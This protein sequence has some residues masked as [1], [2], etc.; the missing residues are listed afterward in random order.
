MAISFTHKLTKPRKAKWHGCWAQWFTLRALPTAWRSGTTCPAHTSAP[1]RSNCA[2]R[3]PMNT[4]RC[5]G[6]WAGTRQTT[7]RKGVFFSTSLWN[8]TRWAWLLLAELPRARPATPRWS[9]FTH[10]SKR[11][12][13]RIYVDNITPTDE[14]RLLWLVIV[15]YLMV[16]QI[17]V[18]QAL[19]HQR[20]NKCFINHLSSVTKLPLCHSFADIK[21]FHKVM[22]VHNLH[23]PA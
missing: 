10:R 4:T 7:G 16:S 14:A 8:T 22:T 9:C 19:S 12:H 3:S 15:K 6:P 20:L 23:L 11:C 21:V 1:W 17:T 18:T 13:W 2:T 5:C